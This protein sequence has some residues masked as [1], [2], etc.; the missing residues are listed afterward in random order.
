MIE[1]QDRACESFSRSCCQFAANCKA[2]RNLH[3][4]ETSSK[5]HD[6]LRSNIDLVK[7]ASKVTQKAPTSVLLRLLGRP[8]NLVKNNLAEDGAAVNFLYHSPH[9]SEVE[10]K[11]SLVRSRLGRGR[12][13]LGTSGQ[14]TGMPLLGSLPFQAKHP[15]LIG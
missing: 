5:D 7:K 14:G 9:Q 6:T 2:T 4:S 8:Q 11:G 10:A 12:C 15:I 1:F 3:I 13:I